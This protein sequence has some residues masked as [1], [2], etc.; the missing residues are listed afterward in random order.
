[1]ITQK[2]R[3]YPYVDVPYHS[4]VAN[5]LNSQKVSDTYFSRGKGQ[6]LALL[7][8]TE[9]IHREWVSSMIDLSDFPYRTQGVKVIRL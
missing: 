4:K 9:T 5:L 8:E 7:E 6:A 2:F 1:M 3:N